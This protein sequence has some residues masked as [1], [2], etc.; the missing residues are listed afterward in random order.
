MLPGAASEGEIIGIT[1]AVVPGEI[2][3][4]DGVMRAEGGRSPGMN[5][6]DIAAASRLEEVRADGA[7]TPMPVEVDGIV[8]GHAV[9]LT[10][11]TASTDAL[12]GTYPGIPGWVVG[13]TPVPGSEPGS[14]VAAQL[15]EFVSW[16]ESAPDFPEVS[17]DLRDGIGVVLGTAMAARVRI[18]RDSAEDVTTVSAVTARPCAVTLTLVQSV[19]EMD[20]LVRN[21]T[22][23]GAFDA[24]TRFYDDRCGEFR[25]ACS[26]GCFD[27]VAG[28]TSGLTP[29]SAG[30]VAGPSGDP[31]PEGWVVDADEAV[32]R[33]GAHALISW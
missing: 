20:S 6:V 15:H 26:G 4:A 8:L 13:A 23:I 28:G 10:F 14:A 3:L 1:P 25:Q 12:I 33:F 18:V 9:A 32:R 16:G 27:E 11:R 21:T 7:R 29:S 31:W 5:T 30:S 2:D 24:G 17:R 19:D 22:A